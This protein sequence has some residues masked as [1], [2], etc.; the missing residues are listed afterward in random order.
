LSKIKMEVALLLGLAAL[1]YALSPQIAAEQRTLNE[2]K[3]KA[4]KIDPKETFLSPLPFNDT[5]KVTVI[6][7]TEGHNNMVPFFGCG[8]HA[9]NL[10]RSNRWRPRYI[11]WIW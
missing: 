2:E 3:K 11:Y 10:Q 1:G 9:I 6:Q 8:S 4:G 5:D 7:A